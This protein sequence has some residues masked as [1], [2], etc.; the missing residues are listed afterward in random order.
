MHLVSHK[1]DSFSEN[2]FQQIFCM[3]SGSNIHVG[4][5]S[6]ENLIICHGPTKKLNLQQEK[7][8]LAQTKKIDQL[9]EKNIV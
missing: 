6:L 4:H 8:T 5:L 3:L 9:N 2:L 1:N 7:N